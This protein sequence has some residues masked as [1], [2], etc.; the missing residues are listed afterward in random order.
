[1]RYYEGSH[2][3]LKDASTRLGCWQRLFLVRDVGNK[4][5]KNAVALHNG[6]TRLGHV[7]RDQAVEVAKALDEM[8]KELG[9]DAVIVVQTFGTID[10]WATSVRVKP[11]AY[12]VER[13]ARKFARDELKKGA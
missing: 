4:Y 8:A 5:D 2:E 10:N 9:G 3:Y 13:P 6:A 7:A 12:C 11:I 1:M